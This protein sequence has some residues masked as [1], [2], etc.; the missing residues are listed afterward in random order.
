MRLKHQHG[1]RHSRFEQPRLLQDMTG[2]PQGA[3]SLL[4]TRATLVPAMLSP[5]NGWL[6]NGMQDT[7]ARGEQRDPPIMIGS[8]FWHRLTHSR[9]ARLPIEAQP[10]TMLLIIIWS[11]RSSLRGFICEYLKNDGAIR[12]KLPST[13]F[14]SE[15]TRIGVASAQLFLPG[16]ESHR[17]LAQSCSEARHHLDRKTQNK[18]CR[19]TPSNARSCELIVGC[20]DHP[21]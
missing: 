4:V 12:C 13:T 17:S 7:A 21:I 18:E 1:L 15:W 6:G 5:K 3:A 8:P 9:S 16:A 2:I 10:C 11:S 19:T 20:Q 14:K